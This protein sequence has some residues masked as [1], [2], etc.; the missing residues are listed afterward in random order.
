MWWYDGRI[1]WE[2]HDRRLAWEDKMHD[3]RL[4]C[5]DIMGG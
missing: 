3:E 5:E 1:K 2:R 4:I